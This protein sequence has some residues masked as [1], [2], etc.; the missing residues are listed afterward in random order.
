MNA[1][2][3]FGIEGIGVWSPE[4]PDWT[5]AQ[6][7]LCSN[8]ECA[9]DAAARP[10]AAILPPGER[11]RAPESVLIALEAAQQACAMAQREPRDLPHVFA[12]SYGDLA[13][14]DYLC[15]TLARA[16][17]EV[18]PTKFHNSVHNAPAGYWA[19]ATGCHENSSAV[20]AGD[21]TFGAGLLEAALLAHGESRDVLLCA[22]DVPA[23]GPLRDVI[24]C[25][26]RFAAALVLAPSSAHAVA[27]AKLRVGDGVETLAPVPPL[28]H[29]SHAGNPAAAS[30]PLL[31]AL[32]RRE[33]AAL[34]IAIA[35]SLNLHLEISF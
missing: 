14:N 13:I 9:A 3:E 7:I 32:A 6:N 17:R 33:P 30:L 11:R 16:P 25:R 21:A 31:A 23:S 15:A 1:A 10:S 19:I 27:R 2:L 8:V 20:S 35:P 4:L 24:A 18:S 34:R 28:L 5:S 26:S 12:S 22:Y 29:A